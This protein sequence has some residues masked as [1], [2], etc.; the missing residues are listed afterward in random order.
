MMHNGFA[1]DLT[2][3]GPESKY[4]PYSLERAQGYCRR[5]AHSH[6]ENFSVATLLLPRRLM[7]HFHNIYAY[8][9]WADDLGDETGGG[10]VALDLL[11]WWREE[12]LRSYEGKAR[13]PVMIAL[14]RTVQRFAIPPQPFLDLL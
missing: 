9:R 1:H 13:H 12:L 3:L 8:C 11:R 14:S 7:P 10:P 5:L 4:A 6:Y 2:L